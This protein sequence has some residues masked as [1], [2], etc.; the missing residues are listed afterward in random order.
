MID[1]HDME[2]EFLA[3]DT[4]FPEADWP[5]C[6]RWETILRDWEPA[7]GKHLWSNLDDA[8][9]RTYRHGTGLQVTAALDFIMLR[10][11]FI[12]RLY[13]D[14]VGR[15]HINIWWL[16]A[17]AAWR[18]RLISRGNELDPVGRY[19]D[20]DGEVTISMPVFREVSTPRWL[21]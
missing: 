11:R 19:E 1:I 4:A 5:V 17:T 14:G 8:L 10:Y 7:R 20:D 16:E 13:D 6:V 2:R 12:E 9:N 18:E 3:S 15:R 21:N